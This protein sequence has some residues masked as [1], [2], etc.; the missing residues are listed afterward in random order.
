[1]EFGSVTLGLS[2]R[3]NSLFVKDTSIA[4]VFFQDWSVE[5]LQ[6]ENFHFRLAGSLRIWLGV[7]FFVILF[8]LVFFLMDLL[9]VVLFSG[10]L[11]K[12]D[13][14]VLQAL[15]KPFFDD[16]MIMMGHFRRDHQVEIV[17]KFLSSFVY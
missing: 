12:V 16:T 15:M 5:R 17:T 2:L 4:L 6:A 9:H 13:D 3:D 7:Y 14:F 11:I 8:S 10:F 1:M